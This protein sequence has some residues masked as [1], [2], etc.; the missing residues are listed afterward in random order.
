MIKGHQL[1]SLR[2]L[3]LLTVTAAV[4]LLISTRVAAQTPAPTSSSHRVVSGERLWEIASDL[5]TGRDLRA[6]ISEI[7]HLNDLDTSDL[8][9]GQ[10]LV[11]PPPGD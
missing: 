7:Q 3:I 5:E 10:V 6:V 1:P 11:L 9:P 2:L 4:F 8:R